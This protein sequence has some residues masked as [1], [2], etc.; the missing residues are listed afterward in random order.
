[1]KKL[2]LKILRKYAQIGEIKVEKLKGYKSY[3][4]LESD[5][6]TDTESTKTDIIPDRFLSYINEV[7]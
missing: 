6:E 5:S 2:V 1:M 4:K 7:D 3:E